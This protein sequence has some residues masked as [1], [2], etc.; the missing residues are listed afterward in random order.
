MPI[1]VCLAFASGVAAALAGRSELRVSPRPPLLTRTFGAYFLF[2]V[3]L[4]V[5]ISVYFYAFHG[6][7]FLLYLVDVRTVPS[8]LALLGFL[9]ELAIGAGGF[10]MG[11]SSVRGQREA[12]GGALAVCAV[13]AGVVAL[14]VG[15]DRLALVGTHAQFEGGFGLRPYGSGA[16]MQGTVAMTAIL[17]IGLAYLLLR[18]QWGGRR[19]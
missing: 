5:P 4:L 18:L 13:L 11:A 10:I 2:A 17:L 19:G 1:L 9:G 6:D 8:A 16:L 7:W 3:L 15:R 12:A 14:V